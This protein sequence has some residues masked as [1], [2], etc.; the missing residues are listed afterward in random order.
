[1]LYIGRR[2][3]VENKPHNVPLIALGTGLLWFGWYGFNAGSELQVDPVTSSAFLNTDIAASFAAVAW[4]FIEWANGRQPKFV[5]LL[6]GAVAG[7]ATITPAAGYVAP[8]TAVIYGILSGL[9][10]YYAVALKNRLGWDD[11]LDVWGV[12]G[13]G[14]FLGIVL[15]GVFAS[16]AWN[17]NGAD[18][19]LAGNGAFFFKQLTAAV[20]CSLWAFLFTYAMLWLINRITPVQVDPH[21]EERGLDAELHG[22]EAYPLGL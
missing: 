20:V 14:G 12:H 13:V 3:V 6:T 9:I 5:G 2:H 19:L 17:P 21:A 11:A 8:T 18:G 22:E 7:L 10:C 1:V 4:L 16:T 15:L